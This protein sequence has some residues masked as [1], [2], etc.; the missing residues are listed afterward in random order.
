MDILVV[1]LTNVLKAY[2]KKKLKKKSSL[3]SQ[4]PI[5]QESLESETT[6]QKSHPSKQNPNKSKTKSPR[7]ESPENPIEAS[8]AEKYEKWQHLMKEKEA[9]RIDKSRSRGYEEAHFAKTEERED[10]FNVA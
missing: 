1:N 4:Q 9:D 3:T 6:S 7:E 10:L 2:E 5:I 8:M